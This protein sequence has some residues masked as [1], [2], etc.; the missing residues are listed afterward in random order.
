MRITGHNNGVSTNVGHSEVTELDMKI[1]QDVQLHCNGCGNRQGARTSDKTI[2]DA[3]AS[4]MVFL[5]RMG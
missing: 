1:R 2:E 5:Y 3:Y 4:S